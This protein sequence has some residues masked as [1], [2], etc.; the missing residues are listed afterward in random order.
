MLIFSARPTSKS[1]EDG[2]GNDSTEPSYILPSVIGDM[3]LLVDHTTHD[4]RAGFS[5]LVHGDG[6]GH[7]AFGV[8]VIIVFGTMLC[9]ATIVLVPTS[10]TA[11]V[12]LNAVDVLF[13]ANLVSAKNTV[14]LQCGLNR[15]S[16]E[17]SQRIVL[18]CFS[19]KISYVQVDTHWIS[20]LEDGPTTSIPQLSIVLVFTPWRRVFNYYTA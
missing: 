13:T 6:A 7:R 20:T 10:D 14:L 11:S 4:L 8:G 17:I 9:A 19:S 12:M 16:V 15:T 2:F 3:Y 18:V 5:L 1:D